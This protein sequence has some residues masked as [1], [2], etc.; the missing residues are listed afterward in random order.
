MMAGCCKFGSASIGL[1]VTVCCV[2]RAERHIHL[3]ATDGDV[4]QVKAILAKNPKLVQSKWNL[5]MTPLPNAAFRGHFEVVEILLASKADPLAKSGMGT[6]LELAVRSRSSK[7]AFLLLKHGARL[8]INTASGLGLIDKVA[9][10]LQKNPNALEPSLGRDGPLHWA[11]AKGQRLVGDFLL[12]KKADVDAEGYAQRTPIHLAAEGGHA[13]FVELLLANGAT[14]NVKAWGRT[15][16]YLAVSSRNQATVQ[17]L[18][19]HKA[20]VNAAEDRQYLVNA[21]PRGPSKADSKN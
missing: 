19:A 20:I 18:L 21:D 1:L 9:E 10:F 14:V 8:D 7:V 12:K 2:V 11:A 16:L 17:L 15:P 3:A 13:A 4:E 6:P 5:D